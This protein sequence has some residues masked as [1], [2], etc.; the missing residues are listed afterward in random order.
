MKKFICGF[1]SGAVLCTAIGA[2]AVNSIYENPY[3]ITVDGEEKTIQ[4]YNIDDYSY[5]KLR[6]IA[7]AVGGFNVSFDNDTIVLSTK[8]TTPTPTTTL[9]FPSDLTLGD[10]PDP[11]YIRDETGKHFYVTND[12]F[13][14]PTYSKYKDIDSAMEK[15]ID[16]QT[17]DDFYFDVNSDDIADKANEILGYK[18]YS[19]FLYDITDK[20]TSPWTTI[21]NFGEKNPTLEFYYQYVAPWLRTL[22]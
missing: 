14:L 21:F 10:I 6:D 11:M 4:G 3:R 7:D 2:F 17:L 5:F 12:E 18:R 20:N 1:L 16:N 13:C 9:T 15:G 8:D 19:S 22:K